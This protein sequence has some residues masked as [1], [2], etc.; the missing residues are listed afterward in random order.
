[1]SFGAVLK[2]WRARRRAS[3][4]DLALSSGVSARHISFLETGRARPSRA[5]ALRLARDLDVPLEA[6]N[7]W[8]VAAGFA[9]LYERRDPDAEEMAM[10]REAVG[11][12][13]DRHDPYPGFA[14]DR[15]W[16]ILRLNPM[17]ARLLGAFAI[18]EGDSLLDAF[19]DHAPLREAI[20]NLDEVAAHTRTRLLAE[21]RHYGGDA[22]LDAAIA[23]LDEGAVPAAET[24]PPGGAFVPVRYRM[25]GVALSF[26]SAFSHFVS[27][28]DVALAEIRVELMFP[29]DEA[30]RGALEAALGGA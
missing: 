23:R 13:I 29:A 26:F 5:M 30:T 27:A 9:P 6:R 3:Q 28:E 14:L 10:A 2:D 16:R 17:A 1:M 12:M 18:G 20:V 24:V 8:L 25:D 21:S 15:H 22:V 4:L 11:W 19:L 7:G